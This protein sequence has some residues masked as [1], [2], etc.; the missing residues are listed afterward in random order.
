M[1]IEKKLK[2]ARIASGFTQEQVAEQIKV[3]RQTISNWETGKSLP[4][5]VSV[6][7]LSDLYQ[8]SLDELL[9]GDPKMRNKII[10]DTQALKNNRRLLLT[11]GILVLITAIIYLLSISLGGAFYDFYSS[12]IWWILMGIG[13]ACSTAY[14]SQKE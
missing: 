14:I 1:N 4:D 2:N 3:S 7:S 11:T 13:I 5:I 9:K 6:V 12:A 10:K 8:I